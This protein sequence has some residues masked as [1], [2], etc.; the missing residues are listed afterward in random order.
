MKEKIRVIIVHGH[1]LFGNGLVEQLGL[2]SD[3][4]VCAVA[5]MFESV[6]ELIFEHRPNLILVKVAPKCGNGMTDLRNLKNDFLQINILAFSCSPEF[7]D[8]YAA[9]ALSSGADGYVSSADTPTGLITA[10]RTISR[11]NQ[12]ISP[13]V[14]PQR[15]ILETELPGFAVLSRREAEV[16]C[17]TG[18]GY[19]TRKI[20]EMMNL[21]VKTIESYRERIR[22]K[23]RLTQGSDLLY[24]SVSFMRGAARRGIV[25][26]DDLQVV[27][28]LL[29]ATA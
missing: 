20:A 12:Y 8:V 18:C 11:G 3:V 5:S 27:K 2:Q 26:A 19:V 7:E 15:K 24:T 9:M 16:F 10:I 23:M 17:L 28:E 29:S 1:C 4:E 14:K 6:P 25:G 13:Q 22:Q 21:K